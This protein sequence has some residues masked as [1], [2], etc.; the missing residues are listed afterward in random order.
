LLHDNSFSCP[1]INYFSAIS[2]TRTKVIFYSTN[3]F[4]NLVKLMQ[5]VQD[6]RKERENYILSTMK[7]FL[8][9]IGCLYIYKLRNWLLSL[10]NHLITWTRL[11]PHERTRPNPTTNNCHGVN[12]SS[13]S[14]SLM[15]Q[16]SPIRLILSF[17]DLPVF[18]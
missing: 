16:S 18:T 12:F 7:N 6:G 15:R 4:I 9:H 3:V 14:S 2:I 10:V 8:F 5:R 11:I 13:K 17:V 1:W